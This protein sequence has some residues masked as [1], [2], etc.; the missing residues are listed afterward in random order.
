MIWAGTTHCLNSRGAARIGRLATR[1][2]VVLQILCSFWMTSTQIPSM[3][4]TLASY[5][6]LFGPYHPQTLAVTV[7]L[8]EALAA[9][10]NRGDGRRLLERAIFDLAKHHGRQHPLCVRA[11][12]SWST[13]LHEDRDAPLASKR[14]IVS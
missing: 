6:G 5:E 13:L 14:D 8:A 2:G 7:A 11:L 4:A 9:S 1:A 10:G 12:G 3:Q